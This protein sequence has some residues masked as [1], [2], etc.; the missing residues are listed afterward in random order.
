MCQPQKC[1]N[2]TEV[3]GWH[4]GPGLEL[5]YFLFHRALAAFVAIWLRFFGE[6]FLALA[7]PPFNPPSLPRAA[8][9]RLMAIK[10]G[11]GGGGLVAASIICEATMLMSVGLLL[12]R[13][14]IQ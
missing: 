2:M 6:S 12:E 14:G 8:A 13:L 1:A 9:A 4:Y 11:E 5:V 7:F 10:V 3:P